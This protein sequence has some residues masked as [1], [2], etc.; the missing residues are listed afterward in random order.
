VNL[1]LRQLGKAKL[2]ERLPQ[3]CELA[4]EFMGIDPADTPVPV[5]P[6]VHYTMGGIPTSV[7][8]AAPL[9]GLFAAGECASSGLHGANRLGSNSLAELCVFGK[10]AGESAAAFAKSTSFG[11]AANLRAQAEEGR[12]RTTALLQRK[13]GTERLADLR[14][15]MVK[16]M[17]R[18]CGIYRTAAEMEQCVREIGELKQRVQKV[19]LQDRALAWNTEWLGTLE[20]GYQLDVAQ[21]M[22]HS[23]VARTESRGAHQRL[24]PGCTERN[25][26]VFLKHT[27]ASIGADGAPVI[28]YSDV[29]I[30]RSKPGTR[31]YGAAGE[32]AERAEHAHKEKQGVV[33]A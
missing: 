13:D 16:S 7:Q 2:R 22:V 21:A 32:A 33:V 17:E 28:S 24:D 25:D 10:V 30:T 29:V 23:A 3:I 12:D 18:G 14:N 9:P 15:A 1:D 26:E 20:L 27:L 6:A 8:A 31:A 4:Q 5:R 19:A 11:H